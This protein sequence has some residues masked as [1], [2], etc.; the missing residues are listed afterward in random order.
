MSSS[1]QTDPNVDRVALRQWLERNFEIR[2]K[3][4]KPEQLIF[5]CPFC[6]PDRRHHDFGFNTDTLLASCWRGKSPKCERGFTLYSFVAAFNSTSYEDARQF[7]ESNFVDADKVKRVRRLVNNLLEYGPRCV[8]TSQQK[9]NVPMP[10]AAERLIDCGSRGCEAAYQWLTETRRIPHEAIELIDPKYLGNAVDQQWRPYANRVFFPVTSAGSS[11]WL[12]YRPNNDE[13]R[14]KTMNPAGS[15]LSKLL[16]LYDF[17]TDS[18]QPAVLTEGL[19]DAWR[20]FLYGANSMPVFGTNISDEQ[21]SLLNHLPCDEVVVCFDG[22]EAGRSRTAVVVD[23]LLDFYLGSVSVMSLEEGD[24][25]DTSFS[26]YDQQY[27]GRVIW[28]KSKI[29]SLVDRIR[30]LSP[31]EDA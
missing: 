4:G 9:F 8:L 20:F 21:I 10:P 31:K 5:D 29:G 11:A 26:V 18:K 1:Q 13:S 25:D 7:V 19:F 30:R 17:Y 12:A 6:D 3:P 24:P 15:V 22:D 2:D 27:H 14:P 28:T 23:K 16:F